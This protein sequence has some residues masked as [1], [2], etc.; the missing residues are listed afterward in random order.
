MLKL[1]IK[2][3]IVAIIAILSY[4]LI[5][6]ISIYSTCRDRRDYKQ[7]VSCYKRLKTSDSPK[8]II[9]GGSNVDHGINSDILHTKYQMPV[10][11][12]GINAGLGLKFILE[13]IKPYIKRGDIVVLSPEYE[14]FYGDYFYGEMVILEICFFFPEGLLRIDWLDYNQLK[15][16]YYSNMLREV[17]LNIF[18]KNV[19]PGQIRD[20]ESKQKRLLYYN[21]ITSNDLNLAALDSLID[22]KKYTQSK[23]AKLLF[24]FPSITKQKFSDEQKLID[25]VSAKIINILPNTFSSPTTHTYDDS[26]FSDTVYHLNAKARDVRTIKL[27]NEINSMK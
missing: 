14:H 8:I 10:I 18:H 9:I 20:I 19:P 23:N 13:S 11:N 4:A 21:K 15:A 2:L 7:Q 27:I 25:N 26:C 16:L 6:Y 3:V 5:T 1:I 24:S 22:F 17:N 12:C